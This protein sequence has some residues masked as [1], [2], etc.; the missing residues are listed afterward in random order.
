M[1]GVKNELGAFTSPVEGSVVGLPVR[2][3]VELQRPA[4]RLG[5][6]FRRGGAEYH[7]ESYIPDGSVEKYSFETKNLK[8]GP[9]YLQGFRWNF[10]D[11]KD[12]I[13]DLENFYVL[14]PPEEMSS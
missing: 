2:V 12:Y 6:S 4:S 10:D 5:F 13:Q 9:A 7:F 8:P 1:A 11:S 3:S 14:T